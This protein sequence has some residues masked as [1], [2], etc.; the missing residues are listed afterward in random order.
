MSWLL[1]QAGERGIF[2]RL[3][4]RE[5]RRNRLASKQTFPKKQQKQTH[6]AKLLEGKWKLYSRGFNYVQIQARRNRF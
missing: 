1:K 6:F 3:H 5:D 4:S 2:K